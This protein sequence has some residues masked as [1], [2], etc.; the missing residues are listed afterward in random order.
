VTRIKRL[1]Y[2]AALAVVP[3]FGCSQ[4]QAAPSPAVEPAP[5][6]AAPAAPGAAITPAD[7]N[8]RL[9]AYAHDSMMGRESGTRGNYMA[10]EYIAAELQRMGLEPA[11]ENGTYFQ[12]IPLVT[13]SIDP[14]SSLASGDSNFT[15]W[16]DFVPMSSLFAGFF[17]FSAEG[18]LEDVEV[19]Y[20]GRIGAETMLAPSQM[21]GKLVV[22]DAPLGPDGSP[23]FQFWQPL[24]GGGAEGYGS[25]AAL[26][27]V[28]LDITPPGFLG[29]LQQPGE[30]LDD[31]QDEEAG[32]PL[33]MLVTER[34]AAQLLGA[35]PENASVGAAGRTASLYLGVVKGSPEAPARN[36]IAILRGSDP[37]LRAQFVSIGS[38]NDHVGMTP[39][40][41]DHDSLRA[42]NAVVRPLGAESQQ[43]P[44]T[45]E[46]IAQIRAILD[47]L[48]A[49]RPGRVD[50]VFNGADD[51]GSGTVSVLEI[52]EKFALASERPRRSIIFVW[53]TAEEKGLFGA[54]YFT[55]HPTVPRDSIVANINMDMVGRGRPDDVELG[56]LGYL[57]VIGSRR[58]STELG[59][60]VETVNTRGGWGMKFDYQ[61]DADGHP[62][63]FY[64]RS[65]H[66][67][68]ARYGIP[69]VFFSTGSHRDYHQLT[70]EAEY[71]DYEQLA[72]V[73]NF[74]YDLTLSLANLDRRPLVDKPKP[75]PNAQCQ[76]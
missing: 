7:L 57:Q 42:F 16:T 46:E 40:P 60:L 41:Q 13:T 62:G 4:P 65:D 72:L 22:L 45:E 17:G 76:Q 49:S 58:L 6:P 25:A 48:Q 75:D 51:D 39:N 61:Y 3:A 23:H 66:Y 71:I 19:V 73:S 12:T 20:G 32:G 11:G 38:H 15:L 35:A 69:I 24:M 54:A 34:V 55:D 36:V 2:V 74:V 33:A 30:S 53:H 9:T 70:D 64:C 37:S 52:A 43:R 68:Y 21:E 31:E 50:S 18:N 47:S 67:M 14:A 5:A 8:D 28:T 10:T 1:S 59:D 29:F 44:P 27:F 26:A 56:E 63:N